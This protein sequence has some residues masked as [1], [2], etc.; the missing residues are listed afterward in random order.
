MSDKT[1]VNLTGVKQI[2]SVWLVKVCLQHKHKTLLF[3][4]I[5]TEELNVVE[6]NGLHLANLKLCL[7]RFQNICL[8]NGGRPRRREKLAK[9]AS[10]SK[11]GNESTHWFSL[12]QK[13]MIYL[14]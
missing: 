3:W 9:L 2:K 4:L 12:K 13:L 14:H 6:G 5:V 10:E 1:Q 8:C 11:L 7:V